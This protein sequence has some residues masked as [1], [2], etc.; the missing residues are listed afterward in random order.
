VTVDLRYDV[1]VIGAGHAGCESA[2]A[3]AR[4]GCAT[5]LV[6]L[7]RDAVARMSCNPA[8]GGLGKGHL[9]REIDALGGV[10]SRLADACGIQFRLLNRSRGP[11][12]RG[13][14]AQQDKALYHQAMQAEL[15]ALP[16]LDLVEGEVAGLLIEDRR[17]RGVRLASG[18]SILAD[19][20]IATTGTFLGGRM[21]TGERQ[22]S[23]GRVGEPAATALS[24]ALR[25]LDLRI[26]R[27]KTGT[28]PR[29]ERASVDLRR[30]EEQHG[31]PDPT[32]FSDATTSTR[33]PQVSCHIAYTNDR[34]H[35]LVMEHRDRSP[36]FNG[37]ICVRGPRYCP[38]LE[39]KVYRFH[40]RVAHSLYIEP[41]GLDSAHLYLNGFSTSMPEDIQL[42]MV[43]AISGLEDCVMARPGYAVEYDYVD[44]TELRPTLETRRVAGLYLAGQINGTTGYEEAAGLGLMAGINAALAAQGRAPLILRRDEA[45]LGVLVDDLVHRGT[46]EPYRM[47]TSRAEYRL[48]LGVDTATRRLTPYGCRVG[49]LD[50]K[51]EHAVATRW[52]VLDTAADRVRS[53]RWLPSDSDSEK[54]ALAGVALDAPARTA[55]LLQHVGVDTARLAEIS[56]VLASLDPNDRRVVIE[57]IRYAGYVERQFREAERV[58]RAGA[59]SIP[60]EFRYVGL[61]GLSAELVEKLESVRPATIGQAARIDGMTPAALSLLAAHVARAPRAAPR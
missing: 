58:A 3:A 25:S 31:D 40:D 35:R 21:H 34:V 2:A 49:L 27:F 10:M 61:A 50:A 51:R 9:V 11:A 36:L 54:L 18:A 16:H 38:S 7:R 37:A 43:H 23:G 55:D 24:D 22:T 56:P 41:E 32:F 57:T 13:P 26:G 19:R 12:V 53:E 59:L 29:L 4:M 48:L 20:V 46:A 42:R 60:D 6:T 15:D 17:I 30:F 1:V 45:Y 33:L 39:D 28:P 47:F 8:I 44:P 14:R 52:Q 5:A